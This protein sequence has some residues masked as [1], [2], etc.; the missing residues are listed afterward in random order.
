MVDRTAQIPRARFEICFRIEEL[1][2]LEIGDFV[3]VRKFISRFRTH[4]HQSALAGAPNFF[5]IEPAL[6]PHHCFHQ[7]RVE[8][9]FIRNRHD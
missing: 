8:L 5:A 9:M 7:H 1:I 3:F 6:A 2:E 4:L